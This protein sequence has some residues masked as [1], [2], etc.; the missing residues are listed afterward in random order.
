[1]EI[2]EDDTE[3]TIIRSAKQYGSTHGVS[4]VRAYIEY[5]WYND[6]VIGIKIYIPQSHKDKAL[7]P[8]FWPSE[9][10]IREWKVNDNP[11]TKKQE[12]HDG[13]VLPGLCFILM[14]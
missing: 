12:T 13:A 1:M 5:N 6:Y 10:T 14:M 2:S 7:S 4:I 11:R 3:D 8:D 9:I